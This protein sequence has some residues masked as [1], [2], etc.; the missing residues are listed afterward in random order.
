[1]QYI[2][3]VDIILYSLPIDRRG[4]LKNHR[5]TTTGQAKSNWYYRH[6]KGISRPITGTTK[7]M[8]SRRCSSNITRTSGDGGSV[9]H[10]SRGRT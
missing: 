3:E 2:R 9:I 6:R 8:T 1:M 10:K 5:N 4:V 7:M